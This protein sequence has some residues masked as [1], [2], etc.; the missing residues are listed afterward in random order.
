MDTVET[1]WLDAEY[2]ERTHIAD[3]ED[4]DEDDGIDGETLTIEEAMEY[5]ADTINEYGRPAWVG[6]VPTSI[7]QMVPHSIIA[8]FL[9]TAKTSEGWGRPRDG[10]DTIL[11]WAKDN[12]FALTTVKE[13]AEIGGVSE[14]TVRTI[15]GER[16]DI[17]RKSDGR[18]YEVRDPKADREAD[19]R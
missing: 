11:G 18:K 3:D 5:I 16:P 13:L 12:T 8:G 2:E 17:F 1:D 6:E 10:R 9:A 19:K 4:G 7:R 15:L 14:A